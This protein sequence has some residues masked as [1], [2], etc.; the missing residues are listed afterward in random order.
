[1]RRRSFLTGLGA[2]LTLPLAAEAQQPAKLPSI[3]SLQSARNE[4]A[5]AFIQA[6]RDAGYLDGRNAVVETRIYGGMP[7]RLP[8]LAEE[9]VALKCDVIVAASPYSIRAATR[10]TSTIPIVGIDLESDPVASGWARSLSHPGGNFTGL[11]LDLPELGG[12]L[13]EL[14]KEAVPGLTRVA[15]LWDFTIGQVQFRATEAAARAAG[16]AVRSLPIQRLGDSKDAFERDARQRLPGVIV[17]S[18]PL[19]AYER[20][21]IGT[22]AL[23]NRLPTISLS[24]LFVGSGGLMAYGPDLPDMYKRAATY[25]DRIL[26]GA[27]VG[28]LPI[29]RPSRFQLVINLTSAKALGLTIPPSLLQRAD[30]VIE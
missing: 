15:M 22:L 7:E 27:K 20:S 6:L 3:G 8:H 14:L 26:K 13:V 5:V 4:N 28:D 16:V 23:K 11:F 10:A 30:Q 9:L 1:M 21:E 24:P 25:V 2:T 12:K 18:S 29:E 19:I 17:L